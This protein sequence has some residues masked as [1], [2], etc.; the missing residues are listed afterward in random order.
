MAAFLTAEAL[1]ERSLADSQIEQ[2]MDD[3]GQQ[4]QAYH[5]VEPQAHGKLCSPTSFSAIFHC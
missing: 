2:A 4:H 1:A 5:T 3:A